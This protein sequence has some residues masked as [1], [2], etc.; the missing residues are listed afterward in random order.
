MRLQKLPFKHWGVTGKIPHEVWGKLMGLSQL[1]PFPQ[2]GSPDSDWA[3]I[4]FW[5]RDEALIL[6]L[7]L[8][9]VPDIELV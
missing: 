9:V 1:N 2:S 6:D 4:E 7:V 3:F 5:S 8:E